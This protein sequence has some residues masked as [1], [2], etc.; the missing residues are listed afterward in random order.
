[1]SLEIFCS[2]YLYFLDEFNPQ[3]SQNYDGRGLA[4]QIKGLLENFHSKLKTYNCKKGGVPPYA[5]QG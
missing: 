2:L 4:V 3:I 5:F 1:M